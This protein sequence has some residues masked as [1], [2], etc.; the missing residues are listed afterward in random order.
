MEA[1]LFIYLH[2]PKSPW[3]IGKKKIKIYGKARWLT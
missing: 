3:P 2:N 1:E